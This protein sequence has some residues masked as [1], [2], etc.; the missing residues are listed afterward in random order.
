MTG[1]VGFPVL[2]GGGITMPE[3]ALE[4]AGGRVA[5]VVDLEPVR[6][7]VREPEGMKVFG[8]ITVV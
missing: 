6:E 5:G 1:P 3:L 8:G 4:V 7:P 2:A